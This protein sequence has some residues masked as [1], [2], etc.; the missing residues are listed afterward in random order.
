MGHC[1][2]GPGLNGFTNDVLADLV[3]WV[4][5]GKA[6]GQLEATT[7]NCGAINSNPCLKRPV[8]PYPGFPKYKGG[9]VTLPGSFTDEVR[10]Q[11]GVIKPAA[12]YLK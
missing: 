10:Q 5:K 4:E 7:F 3:N 12:R 9:D 6:P 1:G 2:G 8:F 11:N